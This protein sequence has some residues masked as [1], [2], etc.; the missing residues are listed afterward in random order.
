M[1]VAWRIGRVES[2]R[3]GERR[4]TGTVDSRKAGRTLAVLARVR[5]GWG[6]LTVTEQAKETGRVMPNMSLELT[7][8]RP[9]GTGSALPQSVGLG[10]RGGATQLYVKRLWIWVRSPCATVA[11]AVLAGG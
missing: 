8:W 7:P 9:A 11:T 3:L 6:V 1:D 2:E 10:Y 4:T 5:P